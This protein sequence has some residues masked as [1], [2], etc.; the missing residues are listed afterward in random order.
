MPAFALSLALFL[1]A[2]PAVA[3]VG[4]LFQSIWNPLGGLLKKFA[5]P[6]A[7]ALE[8][9]E[10]G[11]HDL[12]GYLRRASRESAQWFLYGDEAKR[13]PGWPLR[14]VVKPFLALAIC[15]TL[16]LIELDLGALGWAAKLGTGGAPDLHLPLALL[17]GM[18]L[19]LAGIAFAEAFFDIVDHQPVGPWSSFRRWARTSFVA[20]VVESGSPRS[21]WGTLCVRL[22]SQSGGPRLRSLARSGRARSRSLAPR[23]SPPGPSGVRAFGWC[24]R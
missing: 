21:R 18:M 24:G 9:I 22:R 23:R 8:G 4:Y 5:T 20:S 15:V 13:A 16:L 12:Q 7:G 1:L 10:K 19:P 3:V 17:Q 6:I 14:Y 11:A 2:A